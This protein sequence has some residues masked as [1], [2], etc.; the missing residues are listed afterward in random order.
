MSRRKY[1]YR[2]MMQQGDLE[3]GLVRHYQSAA[4]AR[5]CAHARA[6][7]SP[8]LTFR[9]E[10]SE[11]VQFAAHPAVITQCLAWAVE[12]GEPWGIWGGTTPEE[13]GVPEAWHKTGVRARTNARRR[14]AR[15]RLAALAGGA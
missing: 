14:A 9:I 15:E 4:A 7:A 3:W 8:G 11:P 10:R 1:L 2:V 12:T 5:H 13:R 6:L